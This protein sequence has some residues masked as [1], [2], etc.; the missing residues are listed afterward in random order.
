MNDLVLKNGHALAVPLA[1]V[2][3]ERPCRPDTD[4]FIERPYLPRASVAPSAEE[5]DGSI[6]HATK[7]QNYSVMQQH[8]VYWDTDR[9]GVIW[10]LDTWN[11]F[12]DLGFNI[13]FSFFAAFMI[14]LSLALPTRIGITYLPDPFFRIYPRNNPC[15]QAR[16]EDMWTKYSVSHTHRFNPPPTTMTLSELWN[17]MHGNRLAMDAFGWAA[18]SME[19]VTTFFLIQ[20]DGVVEKED[21]RK[22]IDGSLFF[23]ISNAR[24]NSK[25]GWNK[26]FGFGGDGFVGGEKMLPFGL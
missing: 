16:F 22:V 8:C 11:G 7:Y 10:P 18:A 25:E 19:W 13:L 20:K 2:T 9:D 4:K 24:K 21:V 26:G 15:L 5:P 3:A 17:F 12:R 23:E 6:H 1:P 14:H